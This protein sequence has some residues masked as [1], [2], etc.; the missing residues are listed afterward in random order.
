MQSMRLS[1]SG[2][3]VL[4]E[5][6]AAPGEDQY[7]F[8][9]MKAT[10]VK[11]GSLYPIL[12]R[13]ERMGWI[14]SFEEQID[15]RR[16]GRPRRRLYRLTGMGRPAAQRALEEFYNDLGPAPIWVPRPQGA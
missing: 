11:S 12:V 1:R 15:E 13:F 5:F 2:A 8:G 3:Q 16:E 9:L 7:G 4:K 14:E 10:G 6:L